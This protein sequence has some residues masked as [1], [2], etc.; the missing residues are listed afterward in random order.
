MNINAKDDIDANLDEVCNDIECDL[1]AQAI[2]EDLKSESEELSNLVK[3]QIERM[4]MV[5]TTKRPKK[6]RKQRKKKKKIKV[7]VHIDAKTDQRDKRKKLLSIKDK[8]S[9]IKTLGGNNITRI[10]FKQAKIKCTAGN[11]RKKLR[12]GKY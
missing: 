4:M 8:I 1:E 5:T 3:R 11:V 6:S 2:C 9:S 12:C 7:N 10:Q